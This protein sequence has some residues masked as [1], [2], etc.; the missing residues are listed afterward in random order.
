V[1]KYLHENQGSKAGHGKDLNMSILQRVADLWKETVKHHSQTT[2]DSHPAD[3]REEIQ[4][5]FCDSDFEM[6]TIDFFILPV[7]SLKQLHKLSIKN[8]FWPTR[9]KSDEFTRYFDETARKL[10]SHTGSWDIFRKL[11][12]YL[13]ERKIIEMD[14]N[15]GSSIS[16]TV[17]NISHNRRFDNFFIFSNTFIR[18]RAEVLQTARQRK[19]DMQSVYEWAGGGLAN[20]AEYMLETLALIMKIIDRVPPDY[21]LVYRYPEPDRYVLGPYEHLGKRH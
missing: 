11:I 1:K 17:G 19:R 8:R 18:K 3:S 12:Y 15:D 21:L 5:R 13:S 4:I 14:R 9:Q 7:N 16:R 6:V 20:G 2:D 10:D